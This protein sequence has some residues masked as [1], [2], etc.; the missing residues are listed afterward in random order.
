MKRKSSGPASGGKRTN[1]AGRPIT[2]KILLSMTETEFSAIRHHLEYQTLPSHRSLHAPHKRFTFAYF[3]NSGLISLVVVM[4]N[5]KTV[6]AGIVGRE[7]IAGMPAVA[8]LERS[9]LLEVVQIPG[10][11]FRVRIRTLQKI[12]NAS[13]ELQQIIRKYTLVL[14]LHVAQT[15]ACN[16]LHD[17]D[18]RLA[19][20]LL[21]AQDRV[22]SDTL[23]ITQDFLATM[24]GTDRTTVS[25]AAGLF[26]RMKIIRYSRG[27]VT[28][29]DRSALEGYACECYGVIQ[30]Y[31]GER[32]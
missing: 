7:G 24:L 9:P 20:W 8:G 10:D 28:I 15:A 29:L 21:M 26:Q 12:L 25:A 17:I 2:N 1:S 18:R 23:H 32:Y 31:S 16:R 27:A 14:G 4:A 22:C 11:A 6:E 30:R 19:R 13:P 3:P 5:G